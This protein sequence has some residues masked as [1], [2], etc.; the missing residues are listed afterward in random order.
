MSY[1]WPSESL[2]TKRSGGKVEYE[3]TILEGCS[4][5]LR[6]PGRPDQKLAAGQYSF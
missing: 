2:K 4:A 5:T 1:R 6:L 3:F